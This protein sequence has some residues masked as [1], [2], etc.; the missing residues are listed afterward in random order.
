MAFLRLNGW[1]IPIVGEPSMKWIYI[2]ERERAFDG[3]MLQDRRARKRVWRCK[4]TPLIE[5][6]GLAVEGLVAGTGQQFP[7]DVDSYSTKG[8]A[9]KSGTVDGSLRTAIGA[10]GYGVVVGVTGTPSESKF[11]S[12][13]Y[14]F[15]PSGT[16]LLTAN[17]ASA[18]TDTTGFAAITSATITRDT[19]HKM[20]GSASIKVVANNN[21]GVRITGITA[22][23]STAY[24][25]SSYVKFLWAIGSSSISHKIE[26]RGNVS[27]LINTTTFSIPPN[28]WTRLF[29]SGTTGVSDSSIE[30]RVVNNSGGSLT[31]YIDAN[32]AE[33]KAFPTSFMNLTRTAHTYSLPITAFSNFY[34][35]FSVNMW[36]RGCPGCQDPSVSYTDAL[37]L[38][39][40]DTPGVTSSESISIE[41]GPFGDDKAHLTV[42]TTGSVITDIAS[43]AGFHNN[44]WRMLTASFRLFP[45][46]GDPKIQF[47][48]DGASV[49]FESPSAMPDMRLLSAVDIG[50]FGS[51]AAKYF[52]EPIDDLVIVPYAVPPALVSALYS[53][54]K[55]FGN[56]P[57]VYMDGDFV[58]EDIGVIES[59][60]QI[61]D[62]TNV[63][64]YKDGLWRNNLRQIEFELQEV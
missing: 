41:T 26:I 45:E 33:A 46:Y 18:E 21:D 19:T 61:I 48:V 56:L 53:L 24:T 44:S 10:D 16:N 28:K 22:S 34:P 38:S 29:V 51:G 3:T 14:A 27:G 30:I 35:D 50:R 47:F 39:F 25:V 59:I 13:A 37:L 23:A 42:T 54:G 9:K 17:Q 60:G 20:I 8:L 57:R 5:R 43:A 40:T 1:T 63:S 11:G 31:F 52:Q 62:V 7:F 36:V 64:G 55:P 15:H 2:G 6:D 4:T 32:Q 12:G 58:P 49:G